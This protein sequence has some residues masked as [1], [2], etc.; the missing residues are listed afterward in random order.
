MRFSQL[1]D[2]SDT[3][4]R[5]RSRNAKRALLTE[6][7]QAAGPDDIGV[8][9]Q[10]LSGRLPQGRIGLGPSLVR[11]LD[12]IESARETSLTV[13]EVDATFDRIAAVT[14]KGSQA[15]RRDLL[16]S[17]YA[18]ASGMEQS[19]LSRLVLGE[20][21]QGALEALLADALAEA[22]RIPADAVRRA[23]ML[24]GDLAAVAE[25]VFERGA[26]GLERFRLEPLVPVQPML[27]QPAADMD[28]A[29]GQLGEAALEYKLDGARVQ[30]HRVGRDV[31]IFSRRLN[32]VTASL[33]D[34]VDAT[35]ALPV[36][37]LIADGEVIAL[38]EDGR[39]HP[40]QVTM[41]RF[42]RKSDVGRVGA[43]LPLTLFAFDCL[44][45]DG[46]DL[47]DAPVTERFAALHDATGGRHLVPRLVTGDPADAA[48]FLSGAF[49]AGHEG[50]M[51]KALTSSYAAGSRGG[52]WLKIKDAHTLDLVV[53]AAEW[54]SGRREGWLSNLHLGARDP[55]AGGWVMLGKTFKGLT[56]TTLKW[57]T[58]RL[59]ELEIGREDHVVHV[60]PEL[61]VEI[62][63]SDIQ[64]SSHYPGGL[65]LRFARVK[66]YRDD[67]SAG[68]A[69]TIDMVRAL[70]LRQTGSP[71]A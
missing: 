52:D 22:A 43:E 58:E 57:Q 66:R 63:V 47:I 45:R 55:D 11:D 2:T 54:G 69:D 59:L 15:A 61:V 35:L 39:P 34:I 60:R 70:N 26:D 13:A 19:F 23:V 33:P 42:G 67:K 29:I 17:L 36:D 21:R 50:V 4:A 41:R 9:V 37:R 28:E 5:T 44:H 40:F 65:A 3:V 32:D 31:R 38:R 25:A 1:V 30:I 71:G 46:D 16:A 53:L 12:A 51:A 14:G 68:Q 24:G 18:R 8:V 6:C 48:A 62:A 7:L 64:A 56:D 10:Y 20:L 49:D 27:A